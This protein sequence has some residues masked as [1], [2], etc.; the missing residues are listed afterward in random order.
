M[1]TLSSSIRRIVI[2]LSA[3]GTEELFICVLTGSG[4]WGI[5]WKLNISPIYIEHVYDIVE[6]FAGVRF[7]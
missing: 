2:V 3:Q 7:E 5:R 6:I 4:R 1:P